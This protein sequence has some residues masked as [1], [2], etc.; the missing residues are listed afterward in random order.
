M[1]RVLI[2]KPS[3][4]GDIIHALPVLNALKSAVPGAEVHWVV[5]RGFEGILEGHPMIERLWV[6]S[7]EEWKRPAGL[8][9]TASELGRLI[10]G[11]RAARYDLVIDLQGLLRSG[12]IT[13]LTGAPRRAGFSDARELSHLC[14]NLKVEGGRTCHAVERYLRVAALLGIGV[15]DVAF[16]LPPFG[17]G[18]GFGGPYYV[19]VP[20]A[21]WPSKR[22]PVEY[23]VEVIDSVPIRAVMAGSAA[24][25]EVARAI[26]AR[27]RREVVDMVGKTDLKTL[28]SILKGASF[29][30]SNDSGPMHIAAALSVPV[31][32]VFGPTSELLTGPYG[33]GHR[34]FNSR[35][36]CSPCFR[37]RCASLECMRRVTPEVVIERIMEERACRVES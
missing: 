24:D 22:W 4:L 30:L 18:V 23:F 26:L 10:K 16:P 29:V 14:Y 9:R 37:R 33:H 28:V 31:Y 15:E 21:R 3:S 7:K 1:R 35:M 32:A 36:G 20:G 12:L 6:I 34:V 8:F 2:V 19:V 11:L 5:A 27:T 25:S 17:G 13:V